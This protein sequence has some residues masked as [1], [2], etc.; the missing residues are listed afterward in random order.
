MNLKPVGW[1][2][3]VKMEKVEKEIKDGALAGFV[4]S[5]DKENKREQEGH[6]RGII[7]AFGPLAFSEIVEEGA[8]AEE[9][10]EMWGVK[11]GD[12]VEFHR[13]DGKVPSTPGFE[14]FRVIPDKNIV[15]TVEN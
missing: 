12:E 6:D 2:V 1:Q 13:Y 8:S 11:I 15:A 7:V 3:L 9:R 10:A 5:S 14:E 4:I